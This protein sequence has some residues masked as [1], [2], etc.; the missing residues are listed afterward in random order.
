MRAI[1]TG[2]VL[3]TVTN[4]GLVLAG[5]TN[6]GMELT[7]T[8]NIGLVLTGATNTGLEL[9]RATNTWWN[10]ASHQVGHWHSQESP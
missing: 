10:S 4:A 9:R 7:R 3:I 5:A 6:T 2:R 1:N 8:T